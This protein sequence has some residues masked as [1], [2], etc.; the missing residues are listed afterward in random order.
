MNFYGD[1]D[2]EEWDM[3]I[4]ILST[5]VDPRV[6]VEEM[7]VAKARD[8]FGEGSLEVIYVK[9]HIIRRFSGN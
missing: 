6:K 2:S 5:Q 7:W 1:F 4:G 8:I 9:L 3:L